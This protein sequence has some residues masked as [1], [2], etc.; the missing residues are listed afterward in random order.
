MNH[1][2]MTQEHDRETNV[3]NDDQQL[4]AHAISD[5]V[6]DRLARHS[7][8]VDFAIDFLVH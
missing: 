2:G 8:L 6:C 5:Y 4:H 1:L 7:K 3:V